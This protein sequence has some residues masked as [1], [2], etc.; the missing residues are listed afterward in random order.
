M[1]VDNPE[2]NCWSRWRRY[3]TFIKLYLIYTICEWIIVD[4]SLGVILDPSNPC[5]ENDNLASWIITYDNFSLLFD[6]FLIYEIYKRKDDFLRNFSFVIYLFLICWGFYGCAIVYNYPICSNHS[7]KIYALSVYLLLSLY[8]RASL[9]PYF[10][11]RTRMHHNRI[12][13]INIPAPIPGGVP[14]DFP[15]SKY[16]NDHLDKECSICQENFVIDQDIK[17][18]PC[19]HIF[20]PDCIDPWLGNHSTC[21]ICRLEMRLQS[22]NRV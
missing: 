22:Q 21:P 20:H 1:D 11:I 16:K 6:L 10:R 17:T 9:Y 19:F 2:R 3:P 5:N 18:L 4:A 7:Q 15:V 12:D 13:I 8:I 14:A